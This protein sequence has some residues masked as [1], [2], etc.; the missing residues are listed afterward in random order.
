MALG[1]EII[2]E[3]LVSLGFQVDE[4]SASAFN[5]AI[6]KAKASA[7]TVV[8]ALSAASVAAAKF[9]GQIYEKDVQLQKDAQA[10]GKSIEATRAY[11]NAL[12]VLGTTA[13]QIKNDQRLQG[14]AKELEALGMKMAL[15]EGS[16]AVGNLENLMAAFREL[17][18]TG[19][20]V[21]DWIGYKLKTLASGQLKGIADSLRKISANVQKNLPQIGAAGG[22]VLKFLAT[23][24][25]NLLRLFNVFSDVLERIPGKVKLIAA[26]IGVLAYA[27]RAGPLGK[28]LLLFGALNLLLDDF[29]TYLDGGESLLGPVWQK[30]IDVFGEVKGAIQGA[31]EYVKKLLD[32]SKNE[33][34][35]V[36]WLAFGKMLGTD[37]LDGIKQGAANL[38]DAI[39]TLILGDGE[40]ENATWTEVGAALFAK[41]K[42][43]LSL[44]ADKLSGWGGFLGGIIR[45]KITGDE[46]SSWAEVGSAI[47]DRVENAVK[48]A[49][50]LAKSK[51]DFVAPKVKELITGDEN[52]SWEEV[53]VF[54]WDKVVTAFETAV[55]AAETGLSFVGSK[56]KTLITGDEDATWTEVGK[57]IW[58][59]I[60]DGI[61]SAATALRAD[62]EGRGGLLGEA[63][64]LLGSTL[65]KAHALGEA[66]GT[67][68]SKLKE[69]G[70]LASIWE[71]AS[72]IITTLSDA[73]VEI[74]N[75]GFL[76]S[77]IV[78]VVEGISSALE[79]AETALSW[80]AAIV[81]KAAE[82]G[83][84]DE[85]LAGIAISLGTIA[86][87][88]G[89]DKAAGF[90]NTLINFGK[91][92]TGKGGFGGGVSGGSGG[93]VSGGSGGGIGGMIADWLPEL[94][95]L[96][97]KGASAAKKVL[98]PVGKTVVAAGK[99][100]LAAA[101]TTAGAVLTSG[102]LLSVPLVLIPTSAGGDL[103]EEEY[104]KIYAQQYEVIDKMRNDY[105]N[106]ALAL[107]APQ[108]QSRKDVDQALSLTRNAVESIENSVSPLP[109]KIGQLQSILDG[110]AKHIDLG[111][112]GRKNT[113]GKAEAEALEQ[114]IQSSLDGLYEI[115]H[116][117]PYDATHLAR[118]D[119]KDQS[120]AAKDQ[121]DAAKD[122]SNAA[123]DQ[124]DAAKDQSDAAKDQSD[125][126]GDV[127]DAAKDSSSEIESMSS[128]VTTS[129][130]TMKEGV[131]ARV[132]STGA[133]VFASVETNG[134]TV[135][136]S[137]NATCAALQ[138]AASSLSG[139]AANL[140]TGSA[141]E[142]E[143]GEKKAFS[144]GGIVSSHRSITV[145]EGNHPEAIL[146]L[147]KPGRALSLMRYA[148]DYMGINAG[149]LASASNL[150][151]G[152]A[153]ANAT[154]GYVMQSYTGGSVTNMNTTM[155]APVTMYVTGNNPESIGA[156]AERI[157]ARRL[158]RNV[159][160]AIRI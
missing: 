16:E 64:V 49:V 33:D 92:G 5:S 143:S 122:Q 68:L 97:K 42:V 96:A 35:S 123:K 30:C 48:N 139:A 36:D 128:D 56:I 110:L 106:S 57:E 4:K 132:D 147:D 114:E 26:A 79:I 81:E 121:S 105:N 158:I 14:L 120:D 53:G 126:A 109:E 67:A 82:W 93:G 17:K 153:Y 98:G 150:L 77:A 22:S 146:P 144:D 138:E 83:I 86:A 10:T 15:P 148:L 23:F 60:L 46:Q 43:G 72:T 119:G 37:L 20:Y 99:G 125:A 66:I 71:S 155:Q 61:E 151:G 55:T 12:K 27:I 65:E 137:V 51:W 39:K 134:A 84:L 127:S 19:A 47:W 6:S 59:K 62:G 63:E 40:A 89:L 152:N 100:A 29:F 160:G 7:L 94:S 141:G 75:S 91:G 140:S 21:L 32:A 88:K 154:P 70:T 112:Y 159:K 2:K 156:A 95:W 115:L 24:L 116:S 117:T 11:T 145:G 108:S 34:G 45:E 28:M 73:V 25:N 133:D 8:T 113:Y 90:I 149:T 85:A 31:Y 52:S 136:E 124:S 1:A 135:V 54:L 41:L 157:L 107:S 111:D 80:V 50:T 118:G 44:A 129:V 103:T 87:L 74:M 38:G 130:D 3:Y 9:V 131:Q 102:A 18:L 104:R 142:G 78:S 13:E 69:N 58:Q 101:G 76:E